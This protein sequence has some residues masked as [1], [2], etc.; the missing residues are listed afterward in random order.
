MKE[1]KIQLGEYEVIYGKGLEI[2]KYFLDGKKL[3]KSLVA[4]FKRDKKIKK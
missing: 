4:K 2:Y 3:K 1:V